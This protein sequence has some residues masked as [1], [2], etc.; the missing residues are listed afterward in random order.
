MLSCLCVPTSIISKEAHISIVGQSPCFAWP[1]HMSDSGDQHRRR[2]R[3]PRFRDHRALAT[4]TLTVCEIA[5]ENADEAA[6][7]CRLKAE[8]ITAAAREA[9]RHASVAVRAASSATDQAVAAWEACTEAIAHARDA[10]D[11]LRSAQRASARLMAE[12]G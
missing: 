1:V 7:L 4:H 3:S 6:A 5:A 12:L 11:V 8:E 9:A 10:A 2:S